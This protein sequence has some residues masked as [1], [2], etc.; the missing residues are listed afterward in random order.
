MK[1]I[2]SGLAC[3]SMLLAQHGPVSPDRYPSSGIPRIGKKTKKTG[4]D[5]KPVA[6]P[7]ILGIVRKVGAETL[8]IEA[9]DSRFVS[10]GLTKTTTKPDGLKA[11]DRVDVEVTQ[12]DEGRY[13]AVA[14]QPGEKPKERAGVAPPA[15]P[16][17][18]PD[19]PEEVD[20][21]ATVAAPS[22]PLYEKGDPGPPKLKRGIPAPKKSSAPLVEV[23]PEAAA[24]AAAAPPVTSPP[25]APAVEKPGDPRVALIEKA[26]AAAGTYLDSLPNYL[27]RQITTRYRS[28]S[29]HID[30]QPIDVVTADVIY[31]DHKEQYDNL[32]V[33]GK[34]LKKGQAVPGSWSRGELGGMLG[35]LFSPASG[36]EF[37]FVKDSTI[38]GTPVSVYD[39]DIARGRSSWTI[40]LP[41]QYIESAH[42][43]SVWLEKSTANV[44]RI[45]IEG[46]DIPEAF[47]LD[48]VEAAVDFDNL[49]IGGNKYLVPVHADLLACFREST[50]CE[51]NTI[52]FRNYRR[53]GAG[54]TITFH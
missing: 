53:F 17:N 24:A 40:Q 11:G 4:A 23:P 1:A 18:P 44:R 41:G 38:A 14:I 52:D 22:G 2:L 3:A 51:R 30:W 32:T 10:I 50:Q 35:E 54:S 31:Q 9:D 37:H 48:K 15:Q 7:H 16:K 13:T 27:C 12:D 6:N 28:L 19:A 49:A 39:F 45:E 21:P 25:A 5:G 42:R 26:R 46:V 47:P 20:R 29:H 34:A 43:G 33:G 36:A 8:E